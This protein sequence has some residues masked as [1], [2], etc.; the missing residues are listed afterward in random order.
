MAKYYLT[1]S[2]NDDQADIII[3]GKNWE[4][5][6]VIRS[7]VLKE[8]QRTLKTSTSKNVIK[9]FKEIISDKE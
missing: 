6:E 9:R 4:A 2:I 8:I 3:N 5:Q 7:I 1:V